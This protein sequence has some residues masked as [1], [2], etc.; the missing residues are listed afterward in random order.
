MDEMQGQEVYTDPTRMKRLGEEDRQMDPYMRRMIM[1][2]AL[3]GN[4]GQSNQKM[5]PM[6]AAMGGFARGMGQGMGGGYGGGD[7]AQKGAGMMGIL[8]RLFGGQ[9]KGF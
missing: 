3:A 1:A 5:S 9:A 8:G 6:G 4:G 7:D 2:Q